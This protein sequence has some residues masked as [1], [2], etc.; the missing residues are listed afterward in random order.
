MLRTCVGIGQAHTQ[1]CMQKC[2]QGLC[3]VCKLLVLG[4]RAGTDPLD[5]EVFAKARFPCGW[6]Q[7]C[8]YFGFAVDLSADIGIH[9][10]L[11]GNDKISRSDGQFIR[12]CVV[13]K[14]HSEKRLRRPGPVPPYCCA[15]FCLQSDW[16][17]QMEIGF[18]VERHL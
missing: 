9:W 2:C 16:R 18:L 1:T 11:S 17:L 15:F 3:E 14:N 10:L 13:S 5:F 7:D 8:S 4:L 6:D 12:V